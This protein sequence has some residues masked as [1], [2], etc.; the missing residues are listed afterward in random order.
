[1][2][3]HLTLSRPLAVIDLETTGISPQNDRVV[4]LSVLKILPSGK[5]KHLT[6]RVNPGI[7]IPA[8]ATAIHGITDAD[9]ANEPGFGAIAAS[10]L[11]LLDGCD[12]CGYN[13]E[14]FDLRFLHHEF[15][16][17]S[18]SLRLEG[19]AILDPL[20]I[21]HARERRD[22]AAAVRFYLGREHDDAHSAAADARATAQVLDA[23]L[24]RYSDLPRG[25][26]DLHA[27][28][29]DPRSV[30]AEGR[31]TRVEGQ[32][33][34]AFGKYRGAALD[35]I[36]RQAPEYLRWML[37]ADFPEETKELVR[38]ALDSRGKA[39]RVTPS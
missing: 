13:F 35:A 19:R 11:A 37:D 14:R 20:Q 33:R 8:E 27:H 23:M 2:F 26:A 29:K 7:P 16:R 38:K 36:A 22:L 3:K 12:L 18:M 1:M 28:L 32:V 34:F 25:V 6:R 21:F 4:E 5:T 15:K 39:D 10:L 9:V 31:F 24:A 17:A 30:D